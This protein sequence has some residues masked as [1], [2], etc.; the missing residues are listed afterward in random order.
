VHTGFLDEIFL[1]LGLAEKYKIK[2]L[3]I[4][5]ERNDKL[6]FEVAS[7]EKFR[8]EDETSIADLVYEYLGNMEIEITKV[9]RI[10]ETKTGKR[11]FVIPYKR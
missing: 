10:P 7:N 4:I 6:R 1:E 5:Q 11:K 8:K 2:E 9:D 3:R